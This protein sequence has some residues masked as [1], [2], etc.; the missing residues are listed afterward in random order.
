MSAGHSDPAYF[1]NARKV[2][3]VTQ[4][5]LDSGL[6]V[7]CIG[8]GWTIQP[9]QR[10]DVGHRIDLARGG[11]NAIEN[12]GPQHRRENRQAGGRI[13]A[14]KTNGGTRRARRLPAW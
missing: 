9:G 14:A 13:G 6:E 1:R 4:A 10:F 7:I 12:L 8:C 11:T 2:R 3:R 5:R